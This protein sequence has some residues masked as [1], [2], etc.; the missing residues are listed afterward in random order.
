MSWLVLPISPDCRALSSLAAS[1][2]GV[3]V[4]VPFA[5]RAGAGLTTFAGVRLMGGVFFPTAFCPGR[6]AP[7]RTAPAGF[8]RTVLTAFLAAGFFG[9]GL[10]RIGDIVQLLLVLGVCGATS[11]PSNVRT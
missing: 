2:T 8:L 7:V 4:R 10:L 6:F 9:A 5:S 1:P 11:S 3:T